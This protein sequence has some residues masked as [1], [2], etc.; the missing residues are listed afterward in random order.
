MLYSNGSLTKSSLKEDGGDEYA[1][2]LSFS[3]DEDHQS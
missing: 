2:E 1:V 3:S